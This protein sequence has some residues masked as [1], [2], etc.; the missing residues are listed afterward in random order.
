MCIKK[1]GR[2]IKAIIKAKKDSSEIIDH[3]DCKGVDTVCECLFNICYSHHLPLKLPVCNK[4]KLRHKLYSQEKS[5]KRLCNK[6]LSPALRK[7]LLRKVTEISDI[8]KLAWPAL[9]HFTQYE[10][11]SVC[12]GENGTD[13]ISPL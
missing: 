2:L 9:Q 5:I 6:S 10:K 11:D 12:A 1:T 7:K 8:L 3:L 13:S 4:N